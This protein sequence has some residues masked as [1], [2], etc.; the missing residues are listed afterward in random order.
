MMKGGQVTRVH[1]AF[2]ADD[3]VEEVVSFLKAQGAP[4]YV[5]EVTEEPEEGFD[6]PFIPGP[7]GGGSDTG[8]ALYDQAVDIVV[9][10]QKASTSYIQRRLKI[11]YNRAATLIEEMEENGVISSANHAGKREILAPSHEDEF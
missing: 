7:A 5:N 1:G 2:V 3:E 10:D 8:N 6:S 11:G 4:A 9:R